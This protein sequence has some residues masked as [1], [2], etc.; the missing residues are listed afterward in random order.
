MSASSK[1]DGA[2]FEN[3]GTYK[4]VVQGELTQNWSDRLAGMR[5]T[6]THPDDAAPATTL[7]GHL[8]DQA[9]LSGILNTLYELHR[10]ILSV[11]LL[12]NKGQK[13][14]RGERG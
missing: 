11:E 6:T 7:V 5:I 12:D 10:P 2:K 4:I 13:N 9:Q 3:P 14:T 8:R 1:K